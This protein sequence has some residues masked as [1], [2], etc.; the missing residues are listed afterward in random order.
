MAPLIFRITPPACHHVLGPP[1]A[2]SDRF[3]ETLKGRLTFDAI[4]L[5]TGKQD[6]TDDDS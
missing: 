3:R 1:E 2:T 4:K 6:Y 5:G